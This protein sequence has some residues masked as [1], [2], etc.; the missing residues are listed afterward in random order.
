L[1]NIEKTREEFPVTKQKVFLN[2]SGVSPLPKPVLGA[3]QTYLERSSVQEEEPFDLEEARRLFAELVNAEPAEVA[4]M[5][6]TSTGLCIAANVFEYPSGSNVVTTDL[7]FPSVVYPW[8]RSQLKSQVQVRYVKNVGGAFYL[9]DFEEAVD[10]HT[11]AVAVSHVEYPNGFRNNLKALAEIAHEHGAYLIVDA[12][13]SAGALQID[14]KRDDF[15]FLATSCYK[16]LLGPSGAGFLYVQK[17]LAERFEPVFVGW[18]SVKHE[19]FET[20]E[21]WN[22]RDLRLSETASRF[23][24]GGPSILSYVG[25]AAAL[26]LL[27]KVG[28]GEVESRVLG[29]TSHLIERLKEEGFKVQTPEAAGHRSGIVNFMID[30]PGGKVDRLRGKGIIVSARMN[31]VRV[32]PHFYNTEEELERLVEEVSRLRGH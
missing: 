8:L 30:D 9:E 29:L 7:E 27:L 16:W 15:D 10:N 22:N 13:Q 6:N 21:L 4:L 17:G 26:K 2:H 3:V 31:G 19:V 18:A 25:A 5:P 24:T 14:A 28:V 1:L 12:C 20:V 11:V 23:E 32:S